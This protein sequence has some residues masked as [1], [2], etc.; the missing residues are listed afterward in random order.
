MVAGNVDEWDTRTINTALANPV[1]VA[2]EELRP[3]NLEALLD[4]LGGKLIGAVLGSVADDMVNRSASISRCAV[5]AYVLNAPV[6]ELAM[7]YDIDVGK[8]FLNTRALWSLARRLAYTWRQTYL[9][10]F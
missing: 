4:D 10:F 7:G 5:F 9:V 3:T 6:T 8:H 1:E 2:A